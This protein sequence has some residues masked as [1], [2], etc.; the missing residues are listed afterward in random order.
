MPDALAPGRLSGGAPLLEQVDQPGRLGHVGSRAAFAAQ[1]V[2]HA[3]LRPLQLRFSGRRKL[4]RIH[5]GGRYAVVDAGP[6]SHHRLAA[7]HPAAED[8]ALGSAGEEFYPDLPPVIGDQLENIAF[9]RAFARGLDDDFRRPAVGKQ[10]KAILI[11]FGEAHFIEEGIGAHRVVGDPGFGIFLAVERTCGEHGVGAFL[12]QAEKHRQIDFPPVDGK[13]QG[14]PEAR[15]LQELAPCGI[16]VVEVGQQRDA[17]ALGAR[18]QVHLDG[19]ALLGFLEKGVVVEL[20][21]GSLE[22]GFAGPGLGRD[23][24]R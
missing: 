5:V 2:V 8:V 23:D 17:R 1:F 20:D 7:D 13:R 16:F 6:G 14:A 12:A 3:P 9:E 18:P 22:V 10:A 21:E 24:R 4:A 19:M 15:I 11:A